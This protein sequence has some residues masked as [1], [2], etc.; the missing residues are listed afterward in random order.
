MRAPTEAIQALKAYGEEQDDPRV[1]HPKIQ[2]E[3]NKVL[4]SK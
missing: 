1:S 2:S 3:M 4:T